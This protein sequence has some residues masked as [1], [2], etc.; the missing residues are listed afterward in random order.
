MSASAPYQDDSLQLFTLNSNK[1]LAQ[2]IADYIGVSL[3][4]CTVSNFSDGETQINIEES[5]RGKQVYVI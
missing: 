2:E 1:Q 5:V 4:K 3:G